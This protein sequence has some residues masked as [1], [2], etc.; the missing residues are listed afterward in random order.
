MTKKIIKMFLCATRMFALRAIIFIIAVFGL[1]VTGFTDQDHSPLLPAEQCGQPSRS[2]ISAWPQTDFAR[3]TASFN[4]VL[5]GGPGKDGIR[6][7]DA[8]IFIPVNMSE[9]ADNEPV[10]TV[11]IGEV[12][13]SYPLQILTWHEIVNDRIDDIPFAVTYCPLCNASIVFD[14]RLDGQVLDFGTT[15]SLRNSDLIMYD[16]QT[17]SWFQQY[18]GNGLF[19]ALAGKQLTVLPARIESVLDLKS[20]SPEADILSIPQGFSRAYGANPY[21]GYDT[22]GFPFLF[23]GEVPKGVKPLEYVVIADNKAWALSYLQAE[24]SLIFDDLELNW[25][26]G[27]ASALDTRTISEGRDLGTVTVFK[28]S[29]GKKQLIP[30][31]VSF[32]FVWHAFNPKS[33]IIR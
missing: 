15:G 9:L 24:Q 1:S 22:S 2:T 7:I 33:E 16:R 13:R 3:C 4:E 30:Y 6:S 32:A 21:V 18:T 11:K 28:M 5:S 29:D 12:E 19:G 26:K 31:K 17:E 10:I 20:R 27:Q 25:H 14:R 23:N 8:P